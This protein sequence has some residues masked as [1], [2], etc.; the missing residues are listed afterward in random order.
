MKESVLIIG[1][2]GY[3]GS[4]VT[5][6]LKDSGIQSV[7]FD[8]LSTGEKRALFSPVFEMGDILDKNRLERIFSNYPIKT[9]IFLA[10]L[11]QVGLSVTHPDEFYHT[12]VLGTLNVLDI[13]HSHSVKQLIFASSAAVY[14]NPGKE[15][16]TESC[17]LNPMNPYGRSKMMDE[18]LIDDFCRAYAIRAYKLRFFNVAGCDSEGRS[19]YWHFPALN[20]IPMAFEAMMKKQSFSIFGTNYPTEDGSCLRDYVHVTDV[21]NAHI[22][23]LKALDSG[24][25][26]GVYNVGS[27]KG[28]S[29]KQVLKLCE[30]ISGKKMEILEKPAR[31]GD[32]PV[33]ISDCTAIKID[34]GWTAPNSEMEIIIRDAWNWISKKNISV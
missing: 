28:T 26:G 19:G 5:L 29:V 9:V 4:H 11:T 1:G 33:V 10:A 12:N 17:L 22:L 3:I 25:A 32:P 18:G 31:E 2:A 27:G 34:L 14:G 13:M 24:K 30:K 7:I 15:L 8:N 6:A 16:L 20:L 21:A 23:A